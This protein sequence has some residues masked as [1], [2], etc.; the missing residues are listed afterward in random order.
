MRKIQ[1]WGK[2]KNKKQQVY[3]L[4][5]ENKEKPEELTFLS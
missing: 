2:N 1:K 5:A 4:I 3:G